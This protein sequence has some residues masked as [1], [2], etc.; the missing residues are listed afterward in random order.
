MNSQLVTASYPWMVI[1]MERRQEYMAALEQASV[2]GNI[3]AFVRFIGRV[4]G[5]WHGCFGSKPTKFVILM[6]EQSVFQFI[7]CHCDNKSPH[8]ICNTVITIN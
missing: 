4:M 7:I 8:F 3:E 6:H 5:G 2:E 1:S